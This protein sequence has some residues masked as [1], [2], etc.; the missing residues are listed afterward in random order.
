MAMASS[1]GFA[2]ASRTEG[3]L[4]KRARP[5]PFTRI[6][7]AALAAV[8][9]CAGFVGQRVI[10]MNMTYHLE[11]ETARVR[12]LGQENE[13]LQLQLARARSLDRIEA[14]ARGRLG[15]VPAERRDVVVIPEGRPEG[16]SAVETTAV[17]RRDT[18][19]SGWL[20]ALF[21]WANDRWPGRTA[22]AG[23]T[24]RP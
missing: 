15:M 18:S 19:E 24:E 13:F 11:A 8:L 9:L 17:A 3:R 20:A 14:I 23:S 7:G 6:A 2:V 21:H 5:A 10:L 16:S 1:G 22:E 12:Q 4:W